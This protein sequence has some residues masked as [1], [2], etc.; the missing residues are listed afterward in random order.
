MSVS[1]VC[2]ECPPCPRCKKSAKI[3]VAQADLDR[4]VNGTLIQNAFKY[5]NDDERE[6]MI[7]GY[8][9]ACWEKTFGGSQEEWTDCEACR[10]EQAFLDDPMT[11]AVGNTS[12]LLPLARG[13]TKHTCSD[14]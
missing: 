8:H 4:W 10:K 14:D 3:H 11:A 6:M 1:I 12:E 7:T 2:V 5:L 9:P 13:K